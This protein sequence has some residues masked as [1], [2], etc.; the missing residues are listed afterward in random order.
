MY[1]ANQCDILKIQNPNVTKVGPWFWCVTFLFT[2]NLV[3]SFGPSLRHECGHGYVAVA[4]CHHPQFGCMWC[5]H[6]PPRPC[7]PWAQ[8]T[9]RRVA[10]AWAHA[11]IYAI[12]CLYGR[13]QGVETGWTNG[14]QSKVMG[15]TFYL[16]LTKHS[17]LILWQE[18][19]PQVL[20]IT[21][22]SQLD[23]PELQATADE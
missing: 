13:Q 3:A 19:N 12:Y 23:H 7:L 21:E 8:V 20:V 9:Q 6:A 18:R 10:A 17:N 2:F 1:T 14:N 11:S 16:C 22:H 15:S 4:A 5:W